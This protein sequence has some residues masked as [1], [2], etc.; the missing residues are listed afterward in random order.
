[1]R[2]ERRERKGCTGSKGVDM[3]GRGAPRVKECTG[4]KGVHGE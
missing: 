3:E 1:M 2:N 4:I